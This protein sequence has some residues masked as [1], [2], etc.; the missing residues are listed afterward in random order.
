[1][2][3]YVTVLWLYVVM[4]ST[5]FGGTVY[6]ALVV[7][8]AWSRK[9]PE[10]FVAFVGAP[11]G[12][13]NIAAFWKLAAPLFALSAVV[14]LATAFWVGAQGSPLILSATCAVAA[15]AWT[16]A[17]FRPTIERFLEQG[18]GN[19]SDERLQSEAQR[20]IWLNWVRSVMV[21]VAWWGSLAALATKPMSP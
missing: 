2:T 5:V 1:M 14:A 21:A 3:L 20:W 6:E 16:L 10:S 17:Y 15:V 19:A 7:H 13:M 12:R 9:P 8:P 4:A 11:I 18:D